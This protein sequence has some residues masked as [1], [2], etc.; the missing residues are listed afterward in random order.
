M[1]PETRATRGISG[2]L[3]DIYPAAEDTIISVLV[4]DRTRVNESRLRYDVFAVMASITEMGDSR[5][6]ER[7]FPV[8]LCNWTTGGRRLTGIGLPK[9]FP[10]PLHLAFQHL[11]RATNG[12][13]EISEGRASDVGARPF[14]L[15][16]HGKL[17]AYADAFEEISPLPD[18]RIEVRSAE[19]KPRVIRRRPTAPLPV[20]R[21]SGPGDR[22]S[23][24]TWNDLRLD[25]LKFI[26]A[27]IIPG[28]FHSLRTEVK[29]QFDI[30]VRV[31][32]TST[33]GQHSSISAGWVTREDQACTVTIRISQDLPDQLKYIALAHEVAHY[34]LH[35]PIILAEQMTEQLSWF[36]P[37]ARCVYADQFE[38]YFENGVK[39]EEQAD[40]LAGYLLI[41]PQIPLAGIERFAVEVSGARPYVG[42]GLVTSEEAGW[43]L[44]AEYFPE[45]SLVEH[46]WQNHD[47]MRD[48]AQRELAWARSA[49]DSGDITMYRMMLRAVM[50]RESPDADR[51]SRDLADA[52]RKFWDG[53]ANGS[54]IS[55]FCSCDHDEQPPIIEVGHR[56]ADRQFLG[57]LAGARALMPRIPLVPKSTRTTGQW[58][59]LLDPTQPPASVAEWRQ[60]HP[61]HGVVLYAARALPHA[62]LFG[63]MQELSGEP[64]G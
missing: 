25:V 31:A 62:P 33:A 49:D 38:R 50:R 47:E 37:H 6:R 23:I 9:V 43:R 39:L 18:S 16:N 40:L 34:V 30:A 20:V 24:D 22:H 26:H 63:S 41:P 5:L 61:E 64:A 56:I 2:Q 15:Y 57:P 21:W 35:F 10:V 51:E 13:T 29:R 1:L 19:F 53:V 32:P 3:V 46:S 17:I 58:V 4:L 11:I 52:T 14:M 36:V 42:D 59:N 45:R 48:L 12:I 27:T 55:A 28:T 7:D 44:L 54:G 60:R 8:Y